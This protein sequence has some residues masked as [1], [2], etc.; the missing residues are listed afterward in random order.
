MNVL[1]TYPE[2][3]VGCRICEQWCSWKHEGQVNPTKSR[4]RVHRVHG[5]YLN[6]PVTCMQCSKSPCIAACREGALSKDSA[7]GAVIVDEEKCI[8]CRRCVRACPYGAVAID[9]DKRV[10]LICDLC[11]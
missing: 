11:G 1:V 5:K 6:I 4:I 3:C 7:T 10:V 8:G 9:K 2:R